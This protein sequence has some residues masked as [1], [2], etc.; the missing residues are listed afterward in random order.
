MIA[1]QNK[2]IREKFP[3]YDRLLN[4]GTI[5]PYIQNDLWIA[6]C[7]D[8]HDLIN[9]NSENL[10]EELYEIVI[11]AREPRFNYLRDKIND[12]YYLEER[13]W[14]CRNIGLHGMLEQIV[15]NGL[16][17]CVNVLSDDFA[18]HVKA[19]YML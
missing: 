5:T 1:A 6:I 4:N 7:Y 8:A 15:K 13:G 12:F 16:A 3:D 19:L 2:I 10:A 17:D 14:F 11:N 18:E 9:I